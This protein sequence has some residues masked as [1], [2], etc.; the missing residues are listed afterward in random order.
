MAR[1]LNKATLI[2]N[3]GA[4][5]EVRTTKSGAQV[6]QFSLATSRSW[7]DKA[8]QAQEETQWHRVVA[9]AKLAE[10]VEKYLRKG[11][12]VYVDGEIRY[13]SYEDKDGVT[14][15]TTEI[16]CRE[17]IML[18]G[19]GDGAV[20]SKSAARTAASTPNDGGNEDLPF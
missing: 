4:D 14:K 18:G 11:Q 20:A 12:R 3:L 19:S 9:W 2:G 1:S 5:P 13:G 7:T 6:A 16:N 8:G 15:Y 17:M 10:I